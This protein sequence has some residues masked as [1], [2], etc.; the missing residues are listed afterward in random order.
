LSSGMYFYSIEAGDFTQ[1]RKMLL[2][3]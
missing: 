3:K 1:T 2:I